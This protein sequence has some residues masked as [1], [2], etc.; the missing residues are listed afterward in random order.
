MNEKLYVLL[1]SL[2]ENA[3]EAGETASAAAYLTVRK[4]RTIQSTAKLK[5]RIL[6]RTGEVQDALRQVGEMVYATH[7]G[8]P[9]DSEA[10]LN[11]LQEIDSLKAEIA[12]LE[13]QA[14]TAAPM[15]V[16]PICGAE[17]SED[18][19]YCRECGSKL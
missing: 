19:T 7:M 13:M 8:H 2:R 10:L 14:G 9:S 6:E 1:D 12:E 5:I 3:R 11:K 17:A 16:C 18:D 15:R 4:A